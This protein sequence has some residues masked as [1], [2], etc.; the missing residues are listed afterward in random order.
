V[1]HGL[2]AAY[3]RLAHAEGVVTILDADGEAFRL[4][5]EA[6]PSL[7]KPN[8]AEAERLL[9]RPLAD[10]RAVVDG[11][12]E[13]VARGIPMVVVSLGAQGAICADSRGV[14]QATPPEVES[15]ST[16]GS[17]DS[18]VAGLAVALAR[19]D[20]IIEG[21]RL[22]TAAGA[23]TAMTPGTSLGTEEEIYALLPQVR[24]EPIA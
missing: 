19:G 24:V 7:I 10:Q 9:G 22:G 16:V 12:R 2:H 11:A 4:G 1:P 3:I 8:R 20:D 15:R 21:L 13:L 18:L 17:G 23:A 5:V 6:G 14:W